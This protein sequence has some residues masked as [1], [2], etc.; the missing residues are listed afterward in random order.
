MKRVPLGTPSRLRE[1]NQA[2]KEEEAGKQQL[3][4]E[5]LSVARERKPMHG[6]DRSGSGGRLGGSGHGALP[7]S[8]HVRVSLPREAQAQTGCYR[9]KCDLRDSAHKP[10]PTPRA[11]FFKFKRNVGHCKDFGE[12]Q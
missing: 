8:N 9:K 7:V 12:A 2:K 5:P 3:Q 10:P 6:R 4:A 11:N 1:Q